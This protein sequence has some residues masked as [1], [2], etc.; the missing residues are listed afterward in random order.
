MESN[1]ADTSVHLQRG[2]PSTVNNGGPGYAQQHR[3]EGGR[4]GGPKFLDRIPLAP[5]SHAVAAISEFVG[6]FMFLLFAFGGTNAVN[7]APN[8]G[9]P[10]DL[11]ANP[12]RLLF[13]SLCFGMSLAVNAWVFYRISGGLFNPAVTVGLMVVGAVGVVRG[14]IVIISQFLGGI[15]AAAVVSGLQPGGLHVSTTLADNTSV[16]QGFFIEVFLTAQLV[17]TI[18]MLAVEKHRST[19]MAPVGIGLALFIAQMM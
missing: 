10:E 6:T 4:A 7:T 13:I 3:H 18:M 14:V 8:Q 19:F 12:A 5:K 1:H 15:A 17:F 2:Q 9:Q 11:A 16:V